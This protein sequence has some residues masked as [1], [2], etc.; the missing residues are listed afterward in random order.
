MRTRLQSI[1]TR[2][3]RSIQSESDIVLTPL[4]AT[5]AKLCQNK[6]FNLNRINTYA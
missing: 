4:E 1:F 3:G 6:D 2:H 5:L